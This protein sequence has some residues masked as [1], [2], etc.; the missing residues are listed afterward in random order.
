MKQTFL[1]SI[2]ILCVLC[3]SIAQITTHNGKI[4]NCSSANASAW[5]LVNDI[6]VTGSGNENIK[7]MKNYLINNTMSPSWYSNN[8]TQFVKDNTFDYDNSTSGNSAGFTFA[9]GLDSNYMYHVTVGDIII[10]KLRGNED[11]AI[12]KITQIDTANISSYLF[13]ISFEY[14][15]GYHMNYN[16]I[17]VVTV[18]SISFK[19]MVIWEKHADISSSY[20]VYK[21]ISIDT[22]SL[23]GNV[24]YDSASCF[25]DYNSVP[26]SHGYKYKISVIDTF[27][28]ESV[29]S[30]YHKTMNLVISTFGSTMGLSWTP[31]EDESGFFVPDMYFIYRGSQPNNMQLLDSISASFTSYNDNNVFDS[32][33]YMVSVRK[34]G[35]CNVTG[36]N[37]SES[38]SNK[39]LN[40]DSGVNDFQIKSLSIYPN[41]AN[42]KLSINI[43]EKATLE[44]INV[45]GQIVDT[46]NLTEKSN[47]L[48]LSNLVS[49]VYTLRIKTDRGIAIR[50]LIK[51]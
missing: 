32:Y 19:N 13:D 5:D 34:P 30:Y 44:I 10:A 46:K 35:G 41:P 9:Q 16:N 7:D 23:V 4:W 14:K 24:S 36:R 15:K 11:Y 39:K 38:F 22:Y 25:I 37:N 3:N 28:Y 48:D 26:E 18:D 2:I 29:K 6:A 8:G 17:C 49:G 1:T 33:Y 12:I 27:G 45:Q 20:N 31:Y 43:E 50:K 42:D 21:E 51:Q 47:N 40:F